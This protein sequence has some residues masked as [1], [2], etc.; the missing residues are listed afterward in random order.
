[1]TW[2]QQSKGEWHRDTGTAFLRLLHA[3][4]QDWGWSVTVG[5]K[6]VASGSR[7]TKRQ[8]LADAERAARAM[9]AAQPQRNRSASLLPSTADGGTTGDQRRRTP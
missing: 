1:M 6:T 3:G 9:T 8:A 2:T 7:V 4:W 5:G